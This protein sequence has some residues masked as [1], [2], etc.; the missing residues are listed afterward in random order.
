MGFTIPHIAS[1]LQEVRPF[2]LAFVRRGFYNR[3]HLSLGACPANAFHSSL[4][5]AWVLQFGISPGTVINRLTFTLAFVRRGFYN[6]QLASAQARVT[7]FTLA[8]VRR[9]F[10]N[11]V[12]GVIQE[13]QGV[14]HSSLCSAWVLQSSWCFTQVMG[15]HFHSSLCSAWVLQSGTTAYYLKVEYFH[16]SLCSAWVLQ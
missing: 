12:P 8:F 16:S 14:F 3:R 10:Y 4:C 11:V 1:P 5:S 15:Y 2:T 13:L 6:T 7:A 9:G